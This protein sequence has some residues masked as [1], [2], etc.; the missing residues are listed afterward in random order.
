MI[1]APLANTL[2]VLTTILVSVVLPVLAALAAIWVIASL[3]KGVGYVF[4]LIGRFISHVI[5]F[6]VAQATEVIQL[7]GGMITFAVAAPLALGNL[8]LGRRRAAAGQAGQA[9]AGRARSS[10]WNERSDPAEA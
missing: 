7:A 4:S 3:F 8:A 10:N 2:G 6:A 9:A 1:I 5:T